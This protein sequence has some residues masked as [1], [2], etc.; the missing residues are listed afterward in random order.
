MVNKDLKAKIFI[1]CGQRKET[2]EETT[3]KQIKKMLDDLGYDA[4]LA[5]EEQTLKGLRENIFKQL[6]DSEYFLFIDFNREQI[7]Q[8]GPLHRGSLYSHQELAIASYLDIEFIGFQQDG[9]K[10]DDGMLKV[11]QSNCK[12]FKKTDEMPE[13]IK[14]EI[15]NRKWK[16]NWK[17]QLILERNAKEYEDAH[18]LGIDGHP[19]ARFFHLD[20]KNLNPHKQATNCYGFLESVLNV[21]TSKQRKLRTMEFKWAGYT[22]PNATILR[23][24]ARQL[25]TFFVIHSNP[26]QPHFSCFSDSTYYLPYIE[27]PG[28]VRAPGVFELTFLI[29]SENFQPARETFILELGNALDE[30]HFRRKEEETETKASSTKSPTIVLEP[31]DSP[32]K[33]KNTNRLPPIS[34]Q[35]VV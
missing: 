27:T 15:K 21:N 3:A 18:H 4:Y 1:S 19:M 24:S 26:S 23:D 11:L 25:D 7:S 20:V 30:I 2:I 35:K 17:N 14:K 6:D 29:V 31:K 10:K 16:P 13:L 34:G 5:I 8:E 33:V 9:T 22:L 12:P 32:T 28:D